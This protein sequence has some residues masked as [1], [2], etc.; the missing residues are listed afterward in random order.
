MEPTLTALDWNKAFEAGVVLVT[1]L[2][3]WLQARATARKVTKKIDH[4]TARTE[5][6]VHAADAAANEAKAA[7]AAAAEISR[8]QVDEW[9]VYR[10]RRVLAALETLPECAP[11]YREILKVE[12]RRRVWAK[13]PPPS[14]AAPH[15]PEEAPRHE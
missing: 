3:L 5:D 10:A 15:T 11:C 14:P 1:G 4:N 9:D 8:A 13:Q 7:K 6:A 2:G 12:D